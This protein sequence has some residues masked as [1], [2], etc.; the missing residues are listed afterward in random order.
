MIVRDAE[1]LVFVGLR[2]QGLMGFKKLGLRLHPLKVPRI[3]LCKEANILWSHHEE[4][5]KLPGESDNARNK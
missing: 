1:A 5:R 2:L 3:R 4:T